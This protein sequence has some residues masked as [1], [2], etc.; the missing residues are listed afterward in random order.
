MQKGRGRRDP[1]LFDAIADTA[2][3]SADRDT[4]DNLGSPEHHVR[5]RWITTIEGKR[6]V[7]DR[8]KSI[9]TQGYRWYLSAEYS[10]MLHGMK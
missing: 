3:A 5:S 4:P 6:H 10:G 9:E 7:L 1:Q 2:S 8:I